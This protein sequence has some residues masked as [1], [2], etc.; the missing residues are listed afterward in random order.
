[1]ENNANILSIFLK[2]Q[3]SLKICP[4]WLYV[5]DLLLLF[6]IFLIEV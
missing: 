1:M 3:S 4:L 5:M 2:I 6:F